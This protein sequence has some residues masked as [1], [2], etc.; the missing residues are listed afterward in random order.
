MAHRSEAF[1]GASCGEAEPSPS[2]NAEE[3]IKLDM[4]PF[5]AAESLQNSETL[6]SSSPC[7]SP[8]LAWPSS[9]Q[10]I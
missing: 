10:E 8:M 5:G 9:A 4:E 3:V 1:A 7:E 6:T 2:T